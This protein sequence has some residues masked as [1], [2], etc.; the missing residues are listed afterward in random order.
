MLERYHALERRLA[1]YLILLSGPSPRKPRA[2]E[3]LGGSSGGWQ[4]SPVQASASEGAVQRVSPAAAKPVPSS[5]SFGRGSDPEAPSL[6]KVASDA[7]EKSMGPR[8]GL[9]ELTP[10]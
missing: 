10:D 4:V 3:K 7:L 2:V 5:G 9:I 1:P 8:T 6:L